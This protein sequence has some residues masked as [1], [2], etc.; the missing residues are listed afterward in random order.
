MVLDQA[1]ERGGLGIPRA[2]DSLGQALHIG[3][4][5]PGPRAANKMLSGTKSGTCGDFLVGGVSRGRMNGTLGI[6]VG[7][8]PNA[9]EPQ[10]NRAQLTAG[11]Q[12]SQR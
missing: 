2:V 11:A 12:R 1:I 10:P 6:A 4:N 9:D 5:C 3:S 8:V 7:A